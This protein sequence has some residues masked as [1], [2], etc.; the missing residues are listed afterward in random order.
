MYIKIFKILVNLCNFGF[1]GW[2]AAH[3]RKPKLHI[4][5]EPQE[6]KDKC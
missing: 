5:L 3:P 2:S 6:P 4:E 1:W